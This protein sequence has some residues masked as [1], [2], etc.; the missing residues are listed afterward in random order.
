MDNGFQGQAGQQVPEM[1]DE[2]CLSVS[3]RYIELY[4]KIVGEKFVKADTDNLESRI[5]KNINEY[6]QSR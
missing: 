6:L 1:T 4:E 2:Y 5:E 3:E